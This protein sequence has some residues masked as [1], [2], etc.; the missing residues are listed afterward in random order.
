MSLLGIE[1]S[2]LP[3]KYIYKYF[4]LII[5]NLGYVNIEN[6]SNFCSYPVYFHFNHVSKNKISNISIYLVSLMEVL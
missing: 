4:R 3:E 2:Y 5:L 6:I 1:L